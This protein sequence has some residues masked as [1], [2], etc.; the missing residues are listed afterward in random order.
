MREVRID[1]R[2]AGRLDVRGRVEVGLADLEMDDV[3]P[4]QLELTGAAEHGERR[5]AAEPRDGAAE[6]VVFVRKRGHDARRIFDV[7]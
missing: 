2:F 7:A 5:F 6:I 1:R 4:H 3:A